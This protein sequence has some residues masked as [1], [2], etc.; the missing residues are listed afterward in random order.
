MQDILHHDDSA[1]LATL[2]RMRV[3]SMLPIALNRHENYGQ[4][5]TSS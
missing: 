2:I 3:E 4:N 5:Y 1:R